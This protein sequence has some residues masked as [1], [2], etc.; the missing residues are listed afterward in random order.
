[1]LPDSLSVLLPVRNVQAVLESG[2]REILEVL[3]DLTSRLEILIID[4]GSDDGT[5]EISWDLAARF[6]HVEYVRHPFPLGVIEALRAGFQ[7]TAGAY[8]L[9][10]TNLAELNIQRIVRLWQHRH[11]HTDLVPIGE[12][13]HFASEPGWL[14]R[15]TRW[16]L[17]IHSEN[18]SA[19]ATDNS[20]ARLIHR[21]CLTDFLLDTES[22][23]AGRSSEASSGA[24]YRRDLYDKPA[25]VQRS[26]HPGTAANWPINEVTV[27]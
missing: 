22:S 3:S 16:G 19:S 26:P 10:Q 12:V 4:D 21:H 9:I 25:P 8:L 18:S 24:T 7:T 17:A 6:T 5:E 14:R 13:G 27:D 1:M 20:N 23:R 2:V 11:S 15:L